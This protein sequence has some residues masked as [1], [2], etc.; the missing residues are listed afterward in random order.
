MD[1]EMWSSTIQFRYD[2]AAK[3]GNSSMAMTGRTDG[4]S[5]S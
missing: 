2:A 5:V 1:K 4:M 3:R